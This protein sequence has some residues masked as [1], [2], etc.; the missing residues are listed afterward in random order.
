MNVLEVRRGTVLSYLEAGQS[1]GENLC[2][3]SEYE[4]FKHDRNVTAIED[5]DLCYLTKDDIMSLGEVHVELRNSI[6]YFA[7]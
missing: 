3:T 4:N 2:E 6:E 1:F 5:S 7:A